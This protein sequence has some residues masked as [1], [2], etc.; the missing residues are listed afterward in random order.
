[1]I[2][3]DPARL[4]ETAETAAEGLPFW[5]FWF[6]LCVILML[7]VFIVLRDK[8]LRSRM[9]SFLSG[10]RRK[11]L[12]LR[13]QAKVRK[14]EARKAGV[15]R[16]LG[17]R[18]WDLDL[19][20]E[21]ADPVRARLREIEENIHA[22]QMKWHGL[23]TEIEGQN[24][25]LQEI[26][27]KFEESLHLQED[28]RK[29]LIE[30]MNGLMERKETLLESF[31][32]TKEELEAARGEAGSL[33][34]EIS[35]LRKSA[36]IPEGDKGAKIEKIRGASASLGSWMKE[37]QGNI[38]RLEDEQ[39]RIEETQEKLQS[40][41]DRINDE[42]KLLDAGY[43]AETQTL[44]EMIHGKEAERKRI[45]KSL[46]GLKESMGPLFQSLGKAFE[47]VRPPSPD[48]EIFYLEVDE[49]RA[50]ILDLESRIEKLD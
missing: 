35:A 44:E 39:G 20:D 8:D 3:P 17:E 13:L 19:R 5:L 42:I 2:P 33:D 32:R 4:Q 6:L 45:E 37:T 9:S 22:E 18:A 25:R 43:R 23:I 7:I 31:A 12:R 36:N 24:V 50:A 21:R 15:I 1:M 28:G 49:I 48:L 29:P 30:E 38:A 10:A 41:I 14:E 40:R 16:A 47:E 26:R 46:I 34:K 27:R 11:M